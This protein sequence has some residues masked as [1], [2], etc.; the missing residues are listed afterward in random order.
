[1]KELNIDTLE[2]LSD[3]VGLLL[4]DELIEF[5][6]LVLEQA[7]REQDPQGVKDKLQQFFESQDPSKL[8]EALRCS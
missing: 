6:Y 1:M 7:E 8:I 3:K 2:R 4:S 5:A